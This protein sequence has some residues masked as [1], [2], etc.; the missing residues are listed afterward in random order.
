[1]FSGDSLFIGG[2]A[3]ADFLGGDAGQ[4]YDSIQDVL[5]ALPDEVLLYPGHDYE[6]RVHSTIGGERAANPWLQLGDRDKFVAAITANKPAEPANMAALVRL[7]VEGAAISPTISAAETVRLVAQGAAGS[8]VDVREL[9][10]IES[11]HIPGSRHIVM[12]EVMGRADEIRATPAPRLILCAHGIRAEMVAQA[13]AHLGIG[14]M[15]VIEGG[16]ADYMAAGG[17]V[18]GGNLD[19]AV[20]GGGCCAAAPPP[21]A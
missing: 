18:A 5:L 2:V 1:V 14:G 21:V 20:G 3:R 15:R 13:M 8:I 12:N 16:L 6:G 4:L 10:E 17:E 19:A 11:A 9:D 7:N